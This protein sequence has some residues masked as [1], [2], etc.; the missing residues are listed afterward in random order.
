[1]SSGLVLITG[2]SGLIGIKTIHLALEA[3][4]SV[5][6]A[7][8]SQ[9][10]ANLILATPTVKAINPGPRL[11]FI[12]VPDML[13]DGAYDE[14]VKGTDYIIHIASGTLHGDDSENDYDAHFIQPALKVTVGILDSA[15][16]TTSVRRIVITSSEVVIIPC[17]EFSQKEVDTV[18]D[19]NISCSFNRRQLTYW[20]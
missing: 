11:T 4:Y 15:Y 6:A 16:K 18:F 2:G 17:E 10:K 14:A 9:A 5:R 1:M 7:V 20:I 3:G 19:V 12:V 8:R 13:V